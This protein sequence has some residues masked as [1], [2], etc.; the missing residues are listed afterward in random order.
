MDGW[1][2]C[3]VPAMVWYDLLVFCSCRRKFELSIGSDPFCAITLCAVHVSHAFRQDAA[4][5]TLAENRWLSWIWFV[6]DRSWPYFPPCAL[7]YTI[8][9]CQSGVRVVGA[10][11]HW[12]VRVVGERPGRRGLFRR[13]FA[14]RRGPLQGRRGL[15]RLGFAGRRGPRRVV[16]S[17]L[18][19]CP[20]FFFS[21]PGWFFVND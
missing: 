4:H 11:L 16:A 19:F 17:I 3:T 20:E 14:G 15:F 21:R 5:T 18:F 9:Y 1:C 7:D 2:L 12:D 10:Y 13:G 6:K 8:V